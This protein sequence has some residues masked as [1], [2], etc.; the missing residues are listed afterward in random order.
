MPDPSSHD[1]LVLGGGPAGASTAAVLA[2]HGHDVL[3]VERE[4]FPRYHVGE[5]LIPHCWF[6]LD[7]L[8][9]VEAL[10]DADF[11]QH[12]HSVQFVNTE[13]VRSQP[14]YF[15]EHHDHPSSRTWQVW[16][17]SFDQLLLDNARAQGAEV[18]EETAAKELLWEDGR[19]AGAVVEGPDG[20][21]TEVRARCVV[22]ATGRDALAQAR[23]RW[24]VP[25][26]K[27]KKV[28]V[29]TYYEGALRDP[30]LDEGATTIA[31]LPEKGWFWYLPLACDTASVGIVAEPSY[32]FREGR[33]LEALFD[34]EV[35]AQPWIRD[36]LA[37]GTRIQ[38]HRVTSE[39]TYRSKHCAAD[40]LVLVGDAFSFLDPV[41]SS[42]VFLALQGGVLAGD[43]V[44][45]A[46]EADD[47]TAGRFAEYGRQAREGV[48]AMRGLVHAFY[49]TTFSFGAFFRHYP[50]ARADVTDILIGNLFRDFEPLWDRM[51]AFAELPHALPH[52]EPLVG[53]APH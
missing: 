49:E 29:W 17:G 38:P 39:F 2:E 26:E 24:R 48:E 7:R 30:G 11:I 40:G 44:H 20:T 50:D 35:A 46:L 53:D 32:L 18:R 22:D 42:G 45:A 41:F 37:P 33:D 12:K 28:A 14:F 19:A 6:A 21:R 5:S 43:A 36:H 34:R 25:D 8:G 16:R 1:V 47:V 23:N 4:R 9:V 31:Y 13:G 15:Q 10:D 51:R 3:V 52:G 27:L